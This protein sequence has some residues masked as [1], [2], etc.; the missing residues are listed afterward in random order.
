MGK[1]QKHLSCFVTRKRPKS[2]WKAWPISSENCTESCSRRVANRLLGKFQQYFRCFDM[3]KQPDRP[4]EHGLLQ[5]VLRKHGEE[6]GQQ[7]LESF[8]AI[9]ASETMAWCHG[10]FAP[11]V[12]L[13]LAGHVLQIHE[14][15]GLFTALPPHPRQGWL[16]TEISDCNPRCPWRSSLQFT[17]L[18]SCA[19][20]LPPAT[21]SMPLHLILMQISPQP[22][23]LA[24]R[25]EKGGIVPH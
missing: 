18:C 2:S 17:T 14:V 9:P 15:K 19:S 25:P 8:S 24:A 22:P 1:F 3:R 5:I 10:A 12:V 11:T 13:H 7:I 6:G 16:S 20:G 23:P 21:F 4:G